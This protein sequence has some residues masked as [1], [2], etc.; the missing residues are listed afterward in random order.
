MAYEYFICSQYSP[1]A[2]KIVS[3]IGLPID[4]ESIVSDGHPRKKKLL[5]YHPLNREG[6]K[7]TV[8]IKKAFRI[9]NQKYP[10]QIKK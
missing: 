4:L 8:M 9:L 6:F 5:V 10:L 1:F 7:G 3:P 2:E